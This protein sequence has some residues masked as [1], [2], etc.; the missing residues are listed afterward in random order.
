[1][2]GVGY[3]SAVVYSTVV[4]FVLRALV[5]T[6][7]VSMSTACSLDGSVCVKMSK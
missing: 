4:W 6:A 2:L 7:H 3:Y 1:M 5:T